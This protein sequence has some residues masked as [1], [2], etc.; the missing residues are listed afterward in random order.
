[1]Y[2]TRPAHA[3]QTHLFRSAAVSQ[4]LRCGGNEFRIASSSPLVYRCAYCRLPTFDEGWKAVW[5]K[6]AP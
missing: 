1:M 5:P 6:V 2:S 3:G 4:C